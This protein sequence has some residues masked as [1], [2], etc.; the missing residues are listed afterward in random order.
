MK[1]S[2]EIFASANYPVIVARAK[3]NKEDVRVRSFKCKD[4]GL[5]VISNYSANPYSPITGGKMVPQ[6]K[7][8]LTISSKEIDQLEKLGVCPNCGAELRAHKSVASA[9]DDATFPC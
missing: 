1:K 2:N 7:K 5:S 4:S 3:G 6:S 9:M 8:L